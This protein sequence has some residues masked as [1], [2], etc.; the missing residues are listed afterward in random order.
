[1]EI[2]QVETVH[3]CRGVM[4]T[5]FAYN[6]LRGRNPNLIKLPAQN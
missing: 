1:M 4:S 5:K 6:E 2:V 3:A